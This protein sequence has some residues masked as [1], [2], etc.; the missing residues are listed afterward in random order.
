MGNKLA[1][2]WK[3]VK[4]IK[5]MIEGEK[6]KEKKPEDLIMPTPYA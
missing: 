1:D 2:L 3:E 4:S 6:K 5:G